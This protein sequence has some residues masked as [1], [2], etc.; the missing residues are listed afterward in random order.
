MCSMDIRLAQHIL[1]REKDRLAFLMS[2][3]GENSLSQLIVR[4]VLAQ[5]PCGCELGFIIWLK[6]V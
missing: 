1:Q 3:G 2:R 4:K 6:E 5:G